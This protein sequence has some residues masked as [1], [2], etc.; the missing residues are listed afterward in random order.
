MPIPA[1]LPLHLISA[2]LFRVLQ[3]PRTSQRQGRCPTSRRNWAATYGS[4][5]GLSSVAGRPLRFCVR[6]V[7][8][9]LILTGHAK[10]HAEHYLPHMAVR[11]IC[12]LFIQCSRA[13]LRSSSVLRQPAPD[14]T[15]GLPL[16]P[17]LTPTSYSATFHTTQLSNSPHL[18]PTEVFPNKR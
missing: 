8:G 13:A 10:G 14:L 18:V 7:R 5:V 17:M 15:C 6:F 3:P 1:I 12:V 11:R 9:V 16:S 2:S 4:A